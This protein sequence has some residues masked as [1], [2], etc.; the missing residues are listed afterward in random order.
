M[1]YDLAPAHFQLG[2]LQ[3]WFAAAV[4]GSLIYLIAT[5]KKGNK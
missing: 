5:H 4:I 2:A 1:L 3:T